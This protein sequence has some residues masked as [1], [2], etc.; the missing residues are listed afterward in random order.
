MHAIRGYRYDGCHKLVYDLTLLVIQFDFSIE[1]TISDD[2]GW[3]L[4]G[5]PLEEI[6]L[7]YRDA[8][9]GDQLDY[10]VLTLDG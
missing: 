8:I 9:T 2:D 6:T 7:T 4:Q 10:D 3:R 1:L 5:V